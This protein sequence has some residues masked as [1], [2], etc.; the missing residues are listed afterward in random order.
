MSD[1]PARIAPLQPPYAP[2]VA[3]GACEVDAARQ[4]RRAAAPVS[5]T[6]NVHEELASR[7]RPLGA[8]ILGGARRRCRGTAARGDDPPHLR[9][10]RARSTSGACT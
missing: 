6:L 1:Q 2:T 5:R 8:G 10:D 7:M 3:G 9:A 4:S